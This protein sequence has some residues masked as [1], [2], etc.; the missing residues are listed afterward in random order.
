MTFS[1]RQSAQEK[2]LPRRMLIKRHTYVLELRGVR[3]SEDTSPTLLTPLHHPAGFPPLHCE[4]STAD[5]SGRGARQ[6]EVPLAPCGAVAEFGATGPSS[7]IMTHSIA[8]YTRKMDFD[9]TILEYRFDEA[10]RIRLADR[11]LFEA[12][13]SNFAPGPSVACGLQ[14]HATGHEFGVVYLQYCHQLLV[15]GELDADRTLAAAEFRSEFPELADFEL[16]ATFRN[17]P[18]VDAAKPDQSLQPTSRA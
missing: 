16:P 10:L 3:R 13:D 8:S 15:F 7:A 1:T 4:R 2:G 5:H 9:V 11:L 14:A 12:Q 6:E 18:H 17:E